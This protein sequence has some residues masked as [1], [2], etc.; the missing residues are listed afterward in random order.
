MVWRRPGNNGIL[1]IERLGIN[2]SEILIEINVVLFKKTYVKLSFAKWRLFR[3]DLNSL[4]PSDTTWRHGSGS[5]L[6]QVMACCLTTPI[7]Y[8]NQCWLIII[9]G[10]HLGV[11]GVCGVVV[12]TTNP[13]SGTSRYTGVPINSSPLDK[14]SAVSQTIFSFAFSWIK[15][16]KFR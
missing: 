14:M 1:V 11:C 4:W 13:V 2:F 5:T 3:L 8:L 15:M 7:H 10:W 6:A 9:V 12:M 16:H